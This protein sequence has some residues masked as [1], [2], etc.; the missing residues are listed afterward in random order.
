MVS[1]LNMFISS[2]FCADIAKFS[3]SL[4]VQSMSRE[5][6]GYIYCGAALVGIFRLSD[7]CRS[8][9]AEAIKELKELCIRSAML[10]GDSN[11]AA[12]TAYDQVWIYFSLEFSQPV[13]EINIEFLSFLAK[14]NLWA[15][16]DL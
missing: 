16:E 12:M 7:T 3:D 11:A 14:L 13:I 6:N 8:G 4:D 10:T 5:T 1:Y 9:A 2:N 15:K